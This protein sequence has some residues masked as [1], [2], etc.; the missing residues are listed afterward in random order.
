MPADGQ[1]SGLVFETR[2]NEHGSRRSDESN[3]CACVLV[4]VQC[5]ADNIVPWSRLCLAPMGLFANFEA[6]MS[7]LEQRTGQSDFYRT[8]SCDGHSGASC[9]LDMSIAL[10]QMVDHHNQHCSICL[11][12]TMQ[13]L[14][15]LCALSLQRSLKPDSH[16]N[17]VIVP[18]QDAIASYHLV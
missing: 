11:P 5:F 3:C 15:S 10:F 18:W 4:F 14:Q 9:A 13:L 8:W 1:G 12:L 2:V 16:A 6:I 7:G 17:V